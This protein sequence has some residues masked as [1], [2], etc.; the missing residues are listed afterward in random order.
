MPS[1]KISQMPAATVLLGGELVPLVQGGVNVHA[2]VSWLYAQGPSGP[3]GP[4]G[5]SGLAA[6]ISVAAT[7]TLLPGNSAFVDNV[8]TPES[9]SLIFGVPQGQTGTAATVSVLSTS[10]LLPGS[11]AT[12]NNVGNEYNALLRFGI[13]AGVAGTPGATGAQGPQ[14]DP[15]SNGA[16]ADVAIGTVSTLLP[17]DNAYVTNS[18]SATSAILNFGIPAGTPGVG[19][20]VQRTHLQVAQT[21]NISYVDAAN[22]YYNA[23]LILLAINVSS[24]HAGANL[25]ATFTYSDENQIQRTAQWY[26]MTSTAA[27]GYLNNEITGTGPWSAVPLSL[28]FPDSGSSLAPLLTITA[29]STASLSFDYIL[30]MVSMPYNV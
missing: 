24:I 18:G 15:G 17:G 13:P 5:P 20:G 2:P 3:V 12:V 1:Q 30:S 27:T 25:K 21:G 26:W 10:T 14:G 8:G 16:A 6:T 7:L 9:A 4:P 19:F 11:Q 29:S 28:N 23:G 22:T